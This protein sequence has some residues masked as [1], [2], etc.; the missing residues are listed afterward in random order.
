MIEERKREL[1]QLLQEA[2]KSLVIRHTFGGERLNVPVDVYQKFLE[3][4]WKYYGIDFLSFSFSIQFSPDIADQSTRSNL[5]DYI[6]KEL[7]PFINK[8]ANP[9]LDSIQT[10]S[11]SI[12][13]D[14]T[15]GD[16]LVAHS[17]HRSL[18]LFVVLHRLLEI[19]LVRGI[20]EAVSFFDRCSCLEGTHAFWRDVGLLEGVK[21]EKRVEVFDGVQLIPLSFSGISWE[22]EQ[23][24]FRLPVDAIT[25]RLDSLVGKTLLVIDRSGFSTICRPLEKAFQDRTRI[26]DL[27]F[28]VKVHKVKFPNV[29]A[30][31]TFQ[32]LFCQALSLVCDSPVKIFVG[33]YALEED[34]SF[35]LPHGGSGM[36]R[37]RN[38]LGT[39]TEVKE[40]DIE[41]AKHLY[42]RLVDLGAND[43]EKLRI[44]IDRWIKSKTG[45]DPV[46]KMIDL[47]IAFESLYVPDGG[48]DITHKFSIRAARHLG[49][50]REHR[51]GLLKKFGQIYSRRSDAVHRGK[52]GPT[53]KFEE[54][55]I[56]VSRFITK[57][58]DLCRESILKILE[59]GKFPDWN[60]LILGGDV[61]Q[62]IGA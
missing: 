9:D 51:M 33:F 52:L 4:R 47:G 16:H 13:N 42:E 55:S 24:L 15:Y 32:T 43:R 26:D 56:P 23:Y 41:K 34:K 40:V 62:A 27:P 46:D 5:L 60:S 44:P 30:V 18:P 58:Q 61:E 20:E 19:T 25:D 14:S 11:Y 29:T 59:D 17:I 22:V 50:E 57:A 2:N 35:N 49:R 31:N 8:A 45:W 10:A 28:Q 6:R 1:R 37:Q 36:L 54:D 48:G 39:S 38:R 7:A 53:V 3:E 12:E 21:L